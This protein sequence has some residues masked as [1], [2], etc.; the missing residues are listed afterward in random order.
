[1]T[2][3]EGSLLVITLWLVTILSVLAIAIGRYLSVEI[4]VTKYHLAHDQAKA[5]ARSGI[6]MAAEQLRQDATQEETKRADWLGESWATPSSVAL[7]G[8][9]SEGRITIEIVDAERKL[10]LNALDAAQLQ[11]LVGSADAAAAIVAYRTVREVPGEQPPFYAAKGAPISVMEELLELPRMTPDIF[12]ALQRAAFPFPPSV[13]VKVNINTADEDV[14]QAAGLDSAQ[15]AQLRILRQGS[16]YLVQIGGMPQTELG[17]AQVPPFLTEPAFAA[18]A[19]RF[20]VAS[21]VFAVTSVGRVDA[22]RVSYHVEAVV[23]RAA[24]ARMTIVSWKEW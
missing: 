13:P 5:M 3:V 12:E 15:I 10:N 1:M 16:H 22:P 8:R 17:D 6:Y 9:S 11:P 7:E 24:D 23:Q 20:G 14:L 18:I 2:K 21:S 4:R 19:D